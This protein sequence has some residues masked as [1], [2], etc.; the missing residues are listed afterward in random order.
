MKI[1]DYSAADLESVVAVFRSNIPKHFGPSEEQ[2]LREFLADGNYSED[3]LVGE[4]DGEIVGCGGIGLNED[5]TVSL[6][7]GMVRK[8]HL[9]T[10]LGKQLTEFRIRK[11]AEKFPGRSLVTSTSQHTEGFYERFGFR[12]IERII[13]GFGPGLDNC[14]MRLD[15]LDRE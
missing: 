15:P 14:K 9:G 13:N 12:T 8:D 3:Y 7:W 4:L 11:A 6:C 10:G 1:R 2:G 5:E